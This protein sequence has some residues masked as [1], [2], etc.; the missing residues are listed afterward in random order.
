M[1]AAGKHTPPHKQAAPLKSSESRGRP[2]IQGILTLC[3]LRLCGKC[4]FGMAPAAAVCRPSEKESDPFALL[5][6]RAVLTAAPPER[7]PLSALSDI[8][9]RLHGAQ[10]E[11]GRRPI[12]LLVAL[13]LLNEPEVLTLPGLLLLL[14]ERSHQPNFQSG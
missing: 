2:H 6:G 8:V 5:F 14:D 7:R 4:S 10:G 12:L 11:A 13:L 9:K 1:T 3:V